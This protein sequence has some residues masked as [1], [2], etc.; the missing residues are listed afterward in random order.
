MI[1]STA[2][3]KALSLVFE[4]SICAA[5]PSQSMQIHM[6]MQSI[7]LSAKRP[8]SFAITALLS[9]HDERSPSLCRQCPRIG[10]ID[11]QN[12]HSKYTQ[13]KILVL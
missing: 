2:D 7:L 6:G 9:L 10:E 11:N 3:A 1:G 13:E 5:H 12:D 4:A 8:G